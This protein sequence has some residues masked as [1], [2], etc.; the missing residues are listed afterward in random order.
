MVNEERAGVEQPVAVDAFPRIRR[1]PRRVAVGGNRVRRR[2]ECKDVQN[3]RLVVSTPA[4]GQETRLRSPSVCE[5][6]FAIQCPVPIHSLV[7]RVGDGANLRLAPGVPIEV[8]RSGKGTSEEQGRVDGREFAAPRPSARLHVEEVVVEAPMP[9]RVRSLALR[10]VAEEAKDA[11]GTLDRLVPRQ[12]STLHHDGVRPEG[13]ADRRNAADG[14]GHRAVRDQAGQ[15]MCHVEEVAESAAFNRVEQ[16]V[17]DV[18][19]SYRR[20]HTVVGGRIVP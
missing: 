14:V 10:A 17:V 15:R 8:A 3:Q 11:Q 12:Q 7:E 13:H 2:A 18:G 6:S 4:V 20:R 9:G 19:L 16:R 1:A 5:R